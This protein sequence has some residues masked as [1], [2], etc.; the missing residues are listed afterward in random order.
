MRHLVTTEAPLKVIISGEHGVVH[1]TPGVAL[2]LEPRNRLDLY[3]EKG[4]GMEIK[5]NLV[6]IKLDKKGEVVEENA[7]FK[8]FAGL[9]RHMIQNHGLSLEKKLVAEITSNKA[10]KGTG[11]SASIAASLALALFHHI[12]KEPKFSK[13]PEQN[14]LWA[15]VQAA[16][17]IAHGGRPSGIDAMTVSFGPH[18]LVRK[19]EAGKVKWDFEHRPG[20]TLPK[21][22][23]LLIV[24]TFKKGERAKTGE[25]VLTVARALGITKM[26]EGKEVAKALTEFMPAD[27]N[28]LDGFRQA[29]AKVETELHANGDGKK[30]G[31]AFDA[32]HA[33]LKKLGASTPDIDRVIAEAKKAGSLGGKLTGAG[34]NGGAAIILVNKENTQSVRKAIEA[35]GFIVFEAKPTTEGVRKVKK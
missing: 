28:K 32:N 7:A 10:P 29:Y 12:G 16:D 6:I 21:G 30:L 22:T 9:V 14:E 18:K 34:G 4:S 33:L 3:E 2:S 8:P 15:C 17:E 1:G 13:N 35:S 23:E 5:S 25:M 27:H 11:N 20:L 24:D 26:H 31:Q 19:V